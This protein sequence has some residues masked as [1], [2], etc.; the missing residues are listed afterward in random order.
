MPKLPPDSFLKQKLMTAEEYQRHV[1]KVAQTLFPAEHLEIMS[2]PFVLRWGNSTLGLSTL[3]SVYRR[4]ELPPDERDNAISA[5][6]S[7]IM[8]AVH[9]SPSLETMSWSDAE[10]RLRLQL[11]PSSLRTQAP[12]PLVT[13]PFA[14]GVEIGVVVDL[15]DNYVYVREEDVARWNIVLDEL[16]DRALRNLNEASRGLSLEGTDAPERSLIV[17]TGDGY[18][19]ARLLLPGL[20]AFAVA[21]LGEPCCAAIPN[22]DF[23]FFWSTTNSAAFHQRIRK[24]IRSDVESQPHALTSQIFSVAP[25]H[26]APEGESDS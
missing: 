16:Y 11:F 18:D 17:A 15:P 20:R 25:D 2:D 12:R 24:Q 13:Y 9:N 3:Y 10:P 26:V 7:V 22:R 8:G 21:R 5:H 19:A 23:L 14:F 1:L 6:L 4:D